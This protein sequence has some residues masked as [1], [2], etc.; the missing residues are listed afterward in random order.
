MR[1]LYSSA[2][3]HVAPVWAAVSG[4]FQF[5]KEFSHIPWILIKAYTVLLVQGIQW[6]IDE[7]LEPW[8]IFFGHVSTIWETECRPI[9][10][11][12]KAEVAYQ[13][14]QDLIAFLR[15]IFIAT[16]RSLQQAADHELSRFLPIASDVLSIALSVCGSALWLYFMF[17]GSVDL[18][19]ARQPRP[20]NWAEQDSMSH[21]F[22]EAKVAVHQRWL[23]TA[24][25]R[26]VML[27]DWSA[28]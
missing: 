26:V 22:K 14:L 4:A 19:A 20:L 21:Y 24:D 11:N 15:P 23:Y 3:E 18:T 27:Q 28:Y 6:R 16:G 17:N 9:L 7:A 8:R 10:P 2:K 12:A 1:N 25:D 13:A 5:A